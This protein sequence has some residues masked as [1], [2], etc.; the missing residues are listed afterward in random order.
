MS[1]YN[2]YYEIITRIKL[3]NLLIISHTFF[4]M[5]T[6]IY[7]HSKF[8]VYCTVLTTVIMLYIRSSE[9]VHLI[10]ILIPFDYLPVTYPST[11]PSNP[12]STLFFF[13][14]DYFN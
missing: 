13:E 2:K 8:Q 12:H 3:I 6:Q 9:F 11:T 1:L 10:T 7:S 14:F 4:L 5:R